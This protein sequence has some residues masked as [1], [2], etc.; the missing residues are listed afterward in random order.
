MQIAV[1]LQCF[2][3]AR[4]VLPIPQGSLEVSCLL[5]NGA[6]SGSN[7]ELGSTTV[8]PVLRAYPAYDSVGEIAKSSSTM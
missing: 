4:I 2:N 5:Y 6:L 3:P 7:F 8:A 1:Y